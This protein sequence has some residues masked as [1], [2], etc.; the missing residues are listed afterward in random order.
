MVLV[1]SSP[2][3]LSRWWG[4]KEEEEAVV[5]RSVAK[6]AGS[7]CW[8]VGGGVRGVCR[9]LGGTESSERTVTNCHLQRNTRF[10][11]H[12]NPALV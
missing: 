9:G 1:E 12:N 4:W 11:P 10:R 5:A 3:V 8:G 6:V 7:L 2:P